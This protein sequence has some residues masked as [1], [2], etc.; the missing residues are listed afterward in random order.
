MKIKFKNFCGIFA[1]LFVTITMVLLASCSQ[2]DDNY[3]SDM[4]TLAEMGTRLGGK[5]DPGDG[6][7]PNPKTQMEFIEAGQKDDT[8]HVSGFPL[9]IKAHLEWETAE[10]GS[11]QA[12]VTYGDCINESNYIYFTNNGTRDSIQEFKF[13]EIEDYTHKAHVIGRSFFLGN[14]VIYKRAYAQQNGVYEYG[15][16]QLAGGTINCPIPEDKTY[17]E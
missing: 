9:K 2:D 1:T 13:I 17:F 16:E 12:D 7:T 15:P 6:E 11:A 4:Y 8:L 10:L 3:D 5:G 14:I